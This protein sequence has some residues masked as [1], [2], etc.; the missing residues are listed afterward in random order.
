MDKPFNFKNS[1][2]NR[3]NFLSTVLSYMNACSYLGKHQLDLAF[4]VCHAIEVRF[5]SNCLMRGF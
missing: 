5:Y 2:F 1:N 4:S 3:K